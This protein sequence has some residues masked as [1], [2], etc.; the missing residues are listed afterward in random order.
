MEIREILE[1][2]KSDRET[3]IRE[4][5]RERGITREGKNERGDSVE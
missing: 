2:R 5:E 3:K 4:R 1:R